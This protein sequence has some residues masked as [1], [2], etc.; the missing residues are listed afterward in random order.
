MERKFSYE[1]SAELCNLLG[2][3]DGDRNSASLRMYPDVPEFLDSLSVFL[4]DYRAV[5]GPNFEESTRIAW[6]NG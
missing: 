3:I 5:F 6:E 2:V 1:S 4:G